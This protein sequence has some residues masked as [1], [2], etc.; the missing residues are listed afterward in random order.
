[1]EHRF[2]ISPRTS[3]VSDVAVGRPPAQ[4]PLVKMEGITK[5]FPGVVANDNVDFELLPGEVHALLGEN[6]A[7]KTTLMNILYGLYRPDEGRILLR[8]RE[9]RIRSPRDAIKLG[10]GM[11]HQ[12]FRLVPTLTVAENIAL[13]LEEAGFLFPARK[14]EARI[15]EVAEQYGLKVD[16]GARVWQLSAGEKQRVEILKLLVR[17]ARVLI[18]DEPTA[19]L[20]PRERDDLFKTLRKFAYEGRGIIFITHKLDEVFKVADRVTVL[21]KGRVVAS[22][23]PVEAVSP[24]ELA[25]L[26]VGR[27]LKP[28]AEKRFGAPGGVVLEVRGLCALSDRGM[29][30]VKDVSFEVREGEIFGIAG[31]AGNGQRELVEAIVGLRK[32][33]KGRVLIGGRDVTGKPPAELAKLGVAYI[34]EDRARY[35]VVPDLSVAENLILK[36]YRRPPFK[37]GPFLNTQFIKEWSEKL[38]AEY[39][40]TTPGVDA[41]AGSLSGGNVQ[42]LVLAR[43]LSMRPKLVVASHPTH[44]LDVA[45]TEYIRFLL[46]EQREKGMGILLVSEDLDEILELSDRIAVMHEGRLVSVLDAAEADAGELGLM[47]S[48]GAA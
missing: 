28:R 22:G 8:G 14:V 39:G 19:V 10:I 17:D 11:V 23:L 42:R 4:E 26:M 1:M 36:V 21:R 31:V 29:M 37:R 24:A 18:L 30:A 41:P 2:Y 15:A 35:G 25:R 3:V 12:H 47:M 16:P 34:P 48:R 44:G 33:V 32:P 27:E 9:V 6:G 45:A 40:I 43:E 46:L 7:G 13:A 38:V 20:T 5:R